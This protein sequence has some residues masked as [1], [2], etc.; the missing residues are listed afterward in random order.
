MDFHALRRLAPLGGRAHFQGV[1]RRSPSFRP[2]DVETLEARELM[3]AGLHAHHFRVPHRGRTVIHQQ[4]LVSD[5]AVPAVTVDP[6]LKNAW[7]LAAGATSPWWIA[8]NGTGL[9]T[10]Y[11]GNTGAKAPLTVTI[12]SAS[13]PIGGN[14]T[15]IVASGST[16]DF[17]VNGN[18]TPAHFVFATE[19]GTI[20]AW[21]S[22]T[23]A[24]MKVDHSAS[25]AVYKGLALASD[26][27]G[28]FLY[29]TNFS[30]GKVE[31]FDTNFAPHTF[32]AS[33]FT[34]RRLPAGFAP[35]GISSNN[36]MVFVTYAKQDAGR[37]DDVAGRGLG[38]V[39]VFNTRGDLLGR[40][41]SRG[42]LDSPWGLAVAPSSLGRFAGDLLVGNFGDGRINAFKMTPGGRFRFDG[43][44]SAASGRPLVI[45]GLWG[46]AVGNNAAAGSA[47]TLFFTA[48]LNGE[49]DG[50]FG[51]L[52]ATTATR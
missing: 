34:D 11:N 46:L 49:Q 28:S 17:L 22:G 9:S 41:A 51:T 6:G 12:P 4:N 25:G 42:M 15:G 13:G 16:T 20:S 52:T 32:S 31:V 38:F 18:G 14:P 26:D 29:A 40:V 5:G 48:G 45:D 7:G 2:G 33:Q 19:D 39:D 37:H 24:V 30:S 21:N 43:Q 44:L 8:D 50:L 23:S 47:N 35:F 3:S 1:P 10:I 27:G 36:G